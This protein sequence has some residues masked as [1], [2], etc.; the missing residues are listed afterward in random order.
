MIANTHNCIETMKDMRAMGMR[1]VDVD[2]TDEEEEDG[3]ENGQ[4][5]TIDNQSGNRAGVD[6]NNT[7]RSVFSRA[8]AVA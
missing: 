3:D 7:E 1:L 6:H 5:D 8:L 4:D 2:E